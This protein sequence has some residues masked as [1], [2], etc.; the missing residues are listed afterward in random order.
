MYYYVSDTLMR[1]CRVLSSWKDDISMHLVLGQVTV[2]T[3][4]F[5]VEPLCY[6]KQISSRC[7]CFKVFSQNMHLDEVSVWEIDCK[8][9]SVISK[10]SLVVK[11][12]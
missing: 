12:F 5:L 11:I 7:F 10:T 9:A 6:V 3:V 4:Y 1:V 2:S 8:I